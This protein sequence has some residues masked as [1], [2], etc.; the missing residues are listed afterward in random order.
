LRETAIRAQKRPEHQLSQRRRQQL[1]KSAA[2]SACRRSW[3]CGD[4]LWGYHHRCCR[5]CF[6][7]V[8]LISSLLLL[9]LLLLLPLLLVSLP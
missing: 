5:C 4:R 6:F 3:D 7:F 9:L 1:P 2:S 8:L